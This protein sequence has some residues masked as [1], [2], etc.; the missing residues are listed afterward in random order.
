[1]LAMSWACAICSSSAMAGMADFLMAAWVSLY[2]R[3]SVGS[4]GLASR[5]AARERN[6]C[7]SASSISLISPLLSTRTASMTASAAAAWGDPA[8]DASEFGM[9]ERWR[10]SADVEIPYWDAVKLPAIPLCTDLLIAGASSEIQIE[11]GFDTFSSG[12]DGNP[13]N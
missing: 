10:A 3:R 5:A 7:T 6:C 13:P 1:M 2:S 8:F 11:Q 12:H 4:A 9:W